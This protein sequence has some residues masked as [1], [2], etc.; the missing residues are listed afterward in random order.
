[1]LEKL[2]LVIV[3]DEKLDDMEMCF[4]PHL[5]FE[6]V[7]D[8][9]QNQ[10]IAKHIQQS[11]SF[12]LGIQVSFETVICKNRFSEWCIIV[13]QTLRL[14]SQMMQ[15]KLVYHAQER[16][17]VI[18][19]DHYQV[20]LQCKIYDSEKK[21]LLLAVKLNRHDIM[22]ETVWIL[23]N[24]LSSKLDLDEDTCQLVCPFPFLDK[25]G[26]LT[27][28]QEDEECN[29]GEYCPDVTEHRRSLESIKEREKKRRKIAC[30]KS[31][32]RELVKIYLE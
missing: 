15:A 11:V 14:L 18:E 5:V 20:V 24:E 19:V 12:E 10:W 16:A 27:K 30:Y 6:K 32:R 22:P 3:L 23:L 25:K 4:I 8:L 17:L 29:H 31:R 13:A 1:M 21:A 9:D 26:I 28:G 2:H 7:E